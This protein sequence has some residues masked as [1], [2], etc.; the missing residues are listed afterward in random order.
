MI[1]FN[2][3]SRRLPR[4]QRKELRMGVNLLILI[5][6]VHFEEID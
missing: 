1:M 3:R 2:L 4:L 5:L 6:K